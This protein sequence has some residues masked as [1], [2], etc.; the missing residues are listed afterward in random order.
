MA[1]ILLLAWGLRL[2][3]LGDADVWWDEGWSVWMARKPLLD[4]ALKTAADPHPPLYYWALHGWLALAGPGQFALR[5]LSVA[6][7]LLTVAFT[8]RLGRALLGARVGL[9][10]G[11]LLATARFHVWWSQEIRMYAPMVLLNVAALT[12]F[13]WGCRGGRRRWWG[14]HVGALA[15]GMLT[16][17]LTAITVAVEAACVGWSLLARAPCARRTARA[18]LL[19][20]LGT[21][22]L[23]LPWAFLVARHHMDWS[24]RDSPGA[25]LFLRSY[26][27]VLNT[28]VAEHIER[29]EWATLILLAVPLVGVVLAARTGGDGRSGRGEALAWRLLSVATVV[30][31]ALV[32]LS[33]LP[34]RMAVF[35][36]ALEARYL[37]VM[38][39]AYL[40][41]VAGVVVWL[42]RRQQLLGLAAGA[43]WLALAVAVLPG[44]Y[45][46][47]NPHDDFQSLAAAIEDFQGPSDGI[48]LHS[49]HD[50]PLFAYHYA[51]GRPWYGVPP[52]VAG[53]PV[54][55]ARL[56]QP[57]LAAHGSLWLVRGRRALEADPNEHVARWLVEHSRLVG[58]LPF[59]ER[60]LGLYST[61]PGRSLDTVTAFHAGVRPLHDSRFA[62]LAA[63]A[64]PLSTYVTAQPVRLVTYWKGPAPARRLQIALAA[65]S[66]GFAQRAVEIPAL[67]RPGLHRVESDLVIRRSLPP[68]SYRFHLSDGA[69]SVEF[70]GLQVR[71]LPLP[72]LPPIE[73]AL[74]YD[75]GNEVRLVGYSGLAATLH[76]GGEVR[77]TLF[78]QAQRDLDASRVVF[79]HLLGAWREP[80][81]WEPSVGT[82]GCVAARRPVPYL[83]LERRGGCSRHVPL[84]L[85]SRLPSR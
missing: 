72:S 42:G 81:Y 19:S 75:L 67:A 27:V 38:L 82:A 29:V 64:Q 43:A 68:G 32:Y 83:K 25:W 47:R 34:A 85:R 80:P 22:T 69:A 49:D 71:Q 12:F 4:A 3:R 62:G 58:Q 2:A 28:G 60:Q 41:L 10:A 9:L 8:V 73:R 70:G 48:V 46:A 33:S 20:L 65:S 61:D 50:W 21:G 76:P 77:V 78:W 31:P 7:G 6:C 5:L 44:Y 37:I 1:G 40:A 84:R 63:Y 56:L 79:T 45:G 35:I 51:G 11:L 30:P 53:S 14:W 54:D 55:T 57:L 66:H 13:V 26:W 39:P 17:Y 18:W 74:A 36:P 59:G 24:A 52:A 16:M 15:V 23:L